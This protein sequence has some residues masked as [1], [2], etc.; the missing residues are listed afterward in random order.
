MME[1][2]WRCVQNGDITLTGVFVADEDRLRDINSFEDTNKVLG[3]SR[4]MVAWQ[5][6]GIAMSVYDMCHRYLQERKQF[7]VSLNS[8]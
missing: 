2:V 1:W 7:G 3:V 8:F 5:P 4:V 6:I